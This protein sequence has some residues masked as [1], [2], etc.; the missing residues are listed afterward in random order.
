MLS[1]IPSSLSALHAYGQ[2]LGVTAENIANVNT[3]GYRRKT[4]VLSEGS[5]GDV[6]VHVNP[7][8]QPAEGAAANRRPAPGVT[9]P[10]SNVNNVNLAEEIPS[11][12]TVQRAYE[13]NAKVVQTEDNVL[14]TLLDTFG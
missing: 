9:E 12:V 11:L 13:A 10:P 3:P 7:S 5:Q 8:S 1:A 14:G 2:K 6:T 4:A